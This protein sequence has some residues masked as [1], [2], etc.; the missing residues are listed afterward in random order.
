[1]MR[2]CI[3]GDITKTRFYTW[4]FVAWCNRDAYKIEWI[5]CYFAFKLQNPHLKVKKFLIAFCNACG[6]G[7][8]SVR[9][10]VSAIWDA[11][12]V[13]FCESVD[14]FGKDENS[15]F[16]N[17]QFCIVDD[18]EKCSRK[19]SDSLK[20]KITSDTF[21]YKKLFQDRKTLPSYMDLIATSNSREPCFIGN[22]NRRTELIIINS[23]LKPDKAFWRGFYEEDCKCPRIRGMWFHYLAHK[24]LTLDV[25]SYDCRFDKAALQNHKVKSMKLVHCSSGVVSSHKKGTTT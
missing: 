15:E 17:K 22:D 10:F 11:D 16:L 2:F 5:L 9:A 8:T 3:Q 24:E 1:M 20:S 21:K 4:L 23:V 18:I 6:A 14:D 13:L 7:K 19:E 25:R 12:K